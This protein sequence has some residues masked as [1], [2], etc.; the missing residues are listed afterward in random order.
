MGVATV[1]TQNLI[2]LQS[3]GLLPT[4]PC[5]LPS[6]DFITTD[7]SG[8]HRSA[9]RGRGCR[10]LILHLAQPLWV[11]PHTAP[12][13]LFPHPYP[14]SQH[15][16]FQFTE[17]GMKLQRGTQSLSK[18]EIQS[19]QPSLRDQPGSGHGERL[20]LKLFLWRVGVLSEC[21]DR[22]SQT[23][24]SL[25]GKEAGSHL[26]VFASV[27]VPSGRNRERCLRRAGATAGFY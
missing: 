23:L 19:K 4:L 22:S 1:R 7:P 15:A 11:L 6:L 24:P 18:L 2:E 14:C 27:S 21:L 5:L 17:S 20:H 12:Q 26:A 10:A 9:D 3:S 16:G 13:P 25:G 8:P